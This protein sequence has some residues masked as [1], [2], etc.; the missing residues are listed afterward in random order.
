VAVETAPPSEADALRSVAAELA[1]SSIV[2]E[3]TAQADSMPTDVSNTTSNNGSSNGSSTA[4]P[5]VYYRPGS[6]A[7]LQARAGRKLLFASP[8]TLSY[9]DGR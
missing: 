5:A 3:A 6:R 1:A 4:I 9:L 7:A 8:R 2:I